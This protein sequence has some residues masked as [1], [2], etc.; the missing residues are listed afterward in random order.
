M[1][2]LDSIINENHKEL[3]E[4]WPYIPNHPY[5]ILITGGSGSGKTNVLINLINEQHDIDKIYLYAK[6]LSKTK[7]EYLIKKR[8]D[9][10]VKHV[11]DP[12]A[13]L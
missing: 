3:N 6:D 2:N 4:K 10:G 13:F 7:Y 8:E 12:N 11:N 1:I 5:R 9:A